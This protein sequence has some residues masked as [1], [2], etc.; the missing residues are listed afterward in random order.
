M[1]RVVVVAWL[2][3]LALLLGLVVW[4]GVDVMREAVGHAGWRVLWLGVFFLAPLLLASES[5]RWFFPAGRA[6]GPLSAL[7]ATWVGLAVNWLLPV[8]QVGGEV[9][10]ANLLIRRGAATAPVMASVVVD[11]TA[12]IATQVVYAVIG[13]AL[14]AAWYTEQTVMVGIVA[15]TVF[16]AAV[17]VVFYR[18]QRRGLFVVLVGVADRFLNRAKQAGWREGAAR[19]DEAIV[20][21]YA[22]RRRLL[23]GFALRMGFRIVL[24]G[25][26]MLAMWFLGWPVTV[27]EAM[28]LESLG[29]TVRAS[30]FLIPGGL[31]T[32]EGALVL[33]GTAMGIP[34][35]AALAMALCKRL[36]ELMVGVPALGAW[37]WQEHRH[38]RAVF[39]RNREANPRSTEIQ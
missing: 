5:W 30:S 39:R 11:K 21:V 4:Q 35:H 13:L 32:Q 19:V 12:Q 16:F 3:G 37:Q 14:F 15:G 10:K 33:L 26:V 25:E 1:K 22:H 6:P 20:A 27:V 34:P 23:A 9:V 28:I 29:Q 18:V 31:G 24:V 8:A 2:G 36:R 17:V 38:R 7:H